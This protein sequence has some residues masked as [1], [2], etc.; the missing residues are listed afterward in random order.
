M[1]NSPPS[2][3]RLGE[4]E[5]ARVLAGGIDTLCLSMDVQWQ[6][7]LMFDYLA[8][9]QA[10]AKENDQP[11]PGQN[12]GGNLDPDPWLFNVQPF[13]MKGYQWLLDSKEFRMDIGAWMQPKS[14]PSI[15]A[16]ISSESL[17]LHGVV[18]IV[19]RLANH[20]AAMAG[21]IVSMKVSRLDMCV[22]ILL[23][24]S[25]WTMDMKDLF[26]TR[27]TVLDPHLVHGKLTGFSIG[28]GA[29]S[30]RLY[31][32][33][34]EIVQKSKKFWM[35]GIWGFEAVPE[36]YRVIR[37]EFQLRREALKELGIN[38]YAD[39]EPN[40]GKVWQYCTNWLKVC[41]H[42]ERHIARRHVLPWWVVVQNGYP[43]SQGASPAIREKIIRAD[44]EQII[45]Q[46]L[47]YLA[48]SA[49][50]RTGDKTLEN[51]GIMDIA[52]QLPHLMRDIANL[53]ISDEAF[54]ERV[55]RKRAKY[56]RINP[57]IIE[58]AGGSD[59]MI[60]PPI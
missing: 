31:D 46:L 8:E 21:Q 35:Y 1:T 29:I 11:E 37:V 26:A 55:K 23:P 14:R 49:A 40:I 53:G 39:L 52:S 43:G 25:D 15:M 30:A 16:R 57:K 6:S 42:P 34:A 13:G 41:D 9:L 12:N 60:E 51:A 59:G 36:G 45:R 48:S 33:P 28:R 58:R 5:P 32:K 17:W 4:N 22:D 20:I 47:G 7:S 44:R 2:N 19:Q 3:V 27:A 50:L 18:R 56:R 38:T 54:T 10:K 24:E